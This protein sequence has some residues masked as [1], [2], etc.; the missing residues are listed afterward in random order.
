MSFNAAD[1]D[2]SDSFGLVP[3]G[4][5]DLTLVK[6]EKKKGTKPGAKYVDCQIKVIGGDYAKRMIFLKL[7]LENKNPQTVEISEKLLR[8]LMLSCGVP[9]LKDKWDLSKLINVPAKGRVGIQKG[10]EDYPDDQ[11][12]IQAFIIPDAAE[13]SSSSSSDFEGDKE[14]MKLKK[15]LKK[16]KKS[17]NKKKIKKAQKALD[18]YDDVPF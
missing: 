11:N 5:Y 15:K 16:A 17:G 13:P 6:A 4:T 3:K 10:N 1:G 8:Q 7:N 9:T 18:M 14:L 2:T 12:K